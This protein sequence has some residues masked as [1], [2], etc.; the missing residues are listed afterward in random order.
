MA[1]VG[2]A[3]NADHT[4]VTIVDRRSMKRTLLAS[5]ES[6]DGM[7]L[8]ELREADKPEN[9]TAVIRVGGEEK[10]ISFDSQLLMVGA[11]PA[12][13]P[14][15]GGSPTTGRVPVPALPL[16]AGTQIQVTSNVPPPPTSGM[17]Q[18]PNPGMQAPASPGMMMRPPS[19]F[20]PGPPGFGAGGPSSTRR[21]RRP[22]IIPM[23]PQ[24]TP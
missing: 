16:P 17:P 15:P 9:V 12:V 6:R 21:I 13:A 10:T 14:R 23:R 24:G 5:G 22:I 1:M 8:V 3:R 2:F 20:P 19:G 4:L 11:Q 7:T 18:F